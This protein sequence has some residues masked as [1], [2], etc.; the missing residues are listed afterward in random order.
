LVGLCAS[1][2]TELFWLEVGFLIEFWFFC[3]LFFGFFCYLVRI[4]RESQ[5]S[6]SSV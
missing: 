3:F 6:G 5:D 2:L 1:A 4:I